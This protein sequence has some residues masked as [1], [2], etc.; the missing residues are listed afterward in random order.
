MKAIRKRKRNE[1]EKIGNERRKK[2]ESRRG[3]RGENEGK[4]RTGM[5]R[6]RVKGEGEVRGN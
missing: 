4:R 1:R 2:G 5:R 3:H 6:M